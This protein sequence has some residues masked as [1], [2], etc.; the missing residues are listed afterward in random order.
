MLLFSCPVVSGS[1]LPHGLQH[2]RLPCPSPS[3]R[4]CLSSCSLHQWCHP[5]IWSPDALFSFCP[6]SFPASGT[7]PMSYLFA[8]GDQNTGTS[9]SGSVLPVNIQGWSPLRLT[10]LISFMP[11][12]FSGVFWKKTVHGAKKINMEK[13]YGGCQ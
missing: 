9:A 4:V 10:G 3:P 11:K 12:G 8:S 13:I 6:R 7:L 2:S 5:A 1:L